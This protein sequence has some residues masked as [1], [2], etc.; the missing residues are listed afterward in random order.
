[1]ATGRHFKLGF[2]PLRHRRLSLNQ[3]RARHAAIQSAQEIYAVVGEGIWTVGRLVAFL[4]Q[5]TVPPPACVL[6]RLP[7]AGAQGQEEQR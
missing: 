7:D 2:Q 6:R 4:G 5:D 1:M 3:V